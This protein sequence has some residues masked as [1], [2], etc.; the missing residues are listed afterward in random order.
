MEEITM[1][2]TTKRFLSLAIGLAIMLSTAVV[3]SAG[4]MDWTGSD[5][6]TYT[7]TTNAGS[8]YLLPV[9]IDDATVILHEVGET[10]VITWPA[11][12][13]A[14]HE[15]NYPATVSGYRTYLDR[16]LEDDGLSKTAISNVPEFDYYVINAALPGKTYSFGMEV[17]ACDVTC[18][19]RKSQ[20]A[21]PQTYA[22]ISPSE[23]GVLVEAV[24]SY[25]ACKLI[26]IED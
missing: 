19:I 8:S 11:G 10:N 4:S 24:I 23:T 16:L 9:A 18:T 25:T 17:T 6:Y 13:N 1:K 21:M 7:A 14:V 12:N 2:K 20:V 3:A 5:G 26:V 15:T 22:L